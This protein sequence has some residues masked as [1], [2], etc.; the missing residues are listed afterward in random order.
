[1][2]RTQDKIRDFVE[3]QAFDEL[4]D[5]AAD[6]ARV[7][8]AYRFTDATSDLLA[9]WLDSVADLPRGRGAAQAVAGLRGV[10]K[11]HTLA[12]FG[13]L[14]ASAQLR[15]AVSDAHVATSARRLMNRRHTVVR[16]ERGTRLN[17]GEELADALVKSLGGNAAEWYGAPADVLTQAVARA[18]GATVVLLV[19]TAY[20]RAS[21]VARDDGPLLAALALA[22]RDREAF[23]G[24]ALDDDI[25][26]AEGV[27]VAL[28]QTFRIDYLEPEHLYHVANNY[29][30][31]KSPPARDRLHEIY[32]A[33]RATVPN[34]NWSEPRFAALYPVH[35]LVADVAASVRLHAHSFAFLPFAAAASLRAVNRPALSLILL[36]EVF[37][38][39]EKELR[40]AKDLKDA[41]AVYDELTNNAVAAFPAIQRLQVRLVLKNLFVMS[42]DGRGATA[43]DL[44]AAL[45]L[46]EEASAH[47]PVERV[48]ETLRRLEEHAPAGGIF[49]TSDDGGDTC[50]RFRL[51]SSGVF[52]AA[53]A[54]I[55]KLPLADARAI[56][57]LLAG[58]ARIRFDDWPFAEP[59]QT[60]A[61]D[62]GE[63]HESAGG[64]SL[65]VEWR[66]TL[67]PG[68][69]LRRR[70]DES[71]P[72]P[73][74]VENFEWEVFVLEPGADSA[75]SAEEIAS[76]R[77]ASANLDSSDSH[78]PP[79]CVVWQP[80]E[81]TAEEWGLLRRLHALRTEASL[82]AFGESAR[83]AATTLTARAERVWT[84]LYVD[85]GVLLIDGGRFRFTAGARSNPKVA[86]VLGQV[87][88][89]LFEARYP[90]HPAFAAMLCEQD[91]ARLVE[92]FFS[93][94][95]AA[96][97]AV[98]QLA[99]QFAHLLGLATLRGSTYTPAAGDDA[100]G[101]HWTREVLALIDRA[102]NQT[103]P[104][105]EV[106]RALSRPPSGLTAE[107]RH[108]VLAALVA[109]RRIEL[110]TPTGDRISRRTLGR[111]VNWD[112]V[113][114]I[115]R[116]ASIRHS[117]EELTEWA[118]RLTG[119]EDLPVVT[120]D[121]ACEV[122][123]AALDLWLA[124][125]RAGSVLRDFDASPDAGLTMRTWKLAAFVRRTFEAAAEAVESA[126][127]GDLAL[128]E[129]LQRVADAFA[130][131]PEEFARAARQ[132][133]DLTAYTA[134]V[135]ARER[136]RSYLTAAEPTGVEEIES[137]RRELLHI[138]DDPH[139]LLDA[140]SRD[141]F[142][143]LWH[144]FRERYA[145]H[146]TG[147]HEAAVGASSAHRE[148]VEELTRGEEWREFESLAGLPFVSPR[149]WREAEQL[150]SLA[151]AARCGLGVARLLDERPRCACR[152]RLSDAPE[153]EDA[154]A[155]LAS[156]AARGR[157]AYRRTLAHYGETI[158]AALEHLA[159]AEPDAAA[160]ARTRSLAH[161]FAQG[162]TPPHLSAIDASIIARALASGPSPTPCLRLRLPPD[163]RGLVTRDELQ[164]RVAEWLEE[165]PRVPALV[166]L[167][168]EGEPNAAGRPVS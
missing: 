104:Y 46:E 130:S 56:P 48:E 120:T 33:L 53:L 141:R 63:D 99:E 2:K 39:T 129:V 126:A 8:A 150:L 95:S 149:P 156:L 40:A 31:R 140:D 84:R 98:Q 132:L 100:L 72:W 67:R 103:V 86:G 10:G 161:C 121:D 131:S 71:S 76:A 110:V 12:V 37:D 11:S 54:R 74:A 45:L 80:A 128:E 85:D 59:D 38:Q 68:H 166:E 78:A 90:Q 139:T 79:V 91:A 18:Q 106:C 165:L 142:D 42:L 58:L 152:F 5:F 15:S 162:Q 109:A 112:D 62:E 20:G 127:G 3:P 92:G 115:S 34:F 116:P 151:L 28:S 96:D 124:G 65:S 16:V 167:I 4:H 143:L 1:M 89:P 119:R 75:E 24:L 164:E 163:L 27:N 77:A 148:A 145:A 49:K 25:A 147:A 22:A 108:L 47:S 137:A 41:F 52:D 64:A 133:E 105:A 113:A 107:S 60:A 114:G 155:R 154:A 21:R 6:P 35:P 51:S 73:G 66:G 83:I 70:A 32:L 160:G 135:V 23:V 55:V 9:R 88:A 157:V 144:A 94:A 146:Y 136:A 111:A 36:D 125:W 87:L 81:L 43:R 26:G 153:L 69:L 117:A 29:L 44:C 13:A 168:S 102:G 14:V 17:F 61:A 138:A 97:P 93:G 118:R 123:R 122:V 158:A 7:L 50:Y 159:L 30:L 101:R 19:D 57:E 82:A 134:G